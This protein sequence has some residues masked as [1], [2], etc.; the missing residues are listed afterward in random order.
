MSAQGKKLAMIKHTCAVTKAIINN[1]QTNYD[2]PFLLE[3]GL[4][5]IRLQA[6]ANSYA[7][8]ST[9]ADRFNDDGTLKPAP[10]L[11]HGE[12][13]VKM[14]GLLYRLEKEYIPREPKNFEA[15]V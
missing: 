4:I 5:H 1:V 6:E 3:T 13:H 12:W 9:P 11:Q 10:E 15:S 2:N 14:G 8:R 7:L